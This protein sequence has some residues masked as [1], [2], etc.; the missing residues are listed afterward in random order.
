MEEKASIEKARDVHLAS[1]FA[2]RKLEARVNMLSESSTAEGCPFDGRILKCDLD[3]MDQAKF[4][5]PRNVESSKQLEP[6]WRPQLHVTG[7]IV[8]GVGLLS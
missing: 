4:R 3:G 7:A 5:V 2:D 8:W 6:L 1:M